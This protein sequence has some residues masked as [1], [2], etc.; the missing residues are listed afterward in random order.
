MQIYDYKDKRPIYEQI[1]ERFQT[2]IIRG[3][4]QEDEQLPSVRK[5]AVE[6][7]INPN[8]IQKAYTDLERRGFI[9]S[10]KGRGSFVAPGHKLKE[11]R[12]EELFRQLKN[13]VQEAVLLEIDSKTFAMRA[14]QIYKEVEKHD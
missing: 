7:S 6:N 11:Y 10:V 5:L 2:M 1:A 4:Y 8:T 12:T 13:L 3:V 9:Y 14:E